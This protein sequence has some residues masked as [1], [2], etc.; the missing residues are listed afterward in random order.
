AE[1]SANEKKSRKMLFQALKIYE[2]Y[3]LFKQ[4]E[5]IALKLEKPDIAGAYKKVS[6]DI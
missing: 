6:F 4:C 1:N 5:E 2:E 3:G